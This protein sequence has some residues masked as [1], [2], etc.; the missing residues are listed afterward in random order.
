MFD[1]VIFIPYYTYMLMKRSIL[2]ILSLL[3]LFLLVSVVHAQI[4]STTVSTTPSGVPS[5]AA[6]SGTSIQ[7]DFA[8]DVQDGE[9]NTANDQQA[10][11]NQK[12]EKDNENIGVNEQGEVENEQESVDGQ[13]MNETKD[14][15]NQDG[16]SGSQTDREKMDDAKNG[17]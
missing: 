4:P 14:N 2:P 6:P 16:D 10:Q 15:L 9:R 7:S 12:D 17:Q 11:Q 13:D 3:A 8:K 1:K 5:L